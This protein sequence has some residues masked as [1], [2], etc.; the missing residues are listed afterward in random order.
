MRRVRNGSHRFRLWPDPETKQYWPISAEQANSKPTETV[1]EGWINKATSFT[2]YAEP[3]DPSQYEVQTSMRQRFGTRDNHRA[4][5]RCTDDPRAK[6]ASR[7]EPMVEK[8]WSTGERTYDMFPF[9]IDQIERPF[10]FRTAGVGPAQWMETNEYN[11]MTP[12]QR[13]PPPDPAAGVPEVGS[14]LYGYTGEDTM[15]FA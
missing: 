11:A 7:V 6:I 15:Y 9:Q 1:S 8:V 13:I 10:R 12:Y 14:E 5:A 2:A 4:Q 3:S